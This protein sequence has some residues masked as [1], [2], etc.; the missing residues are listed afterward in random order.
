[1]IPRKHIPPGVK[2]F[3]TMNARSESFPAE[4]MASAPASIP[5]WRRKPKSKNAE[6]LL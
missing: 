4:E 1:M 5:L 3:D 2:L 6:S